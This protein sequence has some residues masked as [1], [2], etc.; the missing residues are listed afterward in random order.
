MFVRC[1]FLFLY[2]LLLFPIYSREEI[3]IDYI[4]PNCYESHYDIKSFYELWDKVDTYT[5]IVR[6]DKIVEDIR[7][8]LNTKELC[9]DVYSNPFIILYIEDDIYEINL[10]KMKK[11]GDSYARKTPFELWYYLNRLLPNDKIV[12]YQR[13]EILKDNKLGEKGFH[14][15]F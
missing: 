11:V 2:I 8:F 6:S 12:D 5:L 4:E 9:S 13:N 14:Y 7:K 3:K 1:C 15:T 10:H